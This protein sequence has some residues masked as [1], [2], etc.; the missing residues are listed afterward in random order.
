MFIQSRNNSYRNNFIIH[1]HKKYFSIKL[2]EKQ[3]RS[4]YSKK[5]FDNFVTTIILTGACL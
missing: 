4:T 1:N 2:K 3:K 5:K